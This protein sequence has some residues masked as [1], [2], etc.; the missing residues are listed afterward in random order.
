MRTISQAVEEVMRREPFLMEAMREGIA[1]NATI[2]RKIKSA[3]EKRLYETVSESSIA[4][5]LHRMQKNVT[6]T[7]YGTH[8]LKQLNDITVRSNLVEFSFP[9]S[10]EVLSKLD[11][12]SNK[13]HRRKD[14]FFSLSR[15]LREAVLIVSADLA[16]EIESVLVHVRGLERINGLSAITMRLP[17]ESLNVPGVYYP[18]L[19]A[20]AHEGISFIEVLSVR[21][22]FGILFED[23]DV[24]RAF[25][26]LKRIT[27]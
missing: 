22:E 1:N 27:S 23:K 25:S 8:F 18:I 20:L 21:T 6:A 26:V 10:S 4:M 5:A 17:D 3:V 15:G 7:N 14:E 19:R 12:I 11:A 2:A 24:D 9:N 13:A 16:D